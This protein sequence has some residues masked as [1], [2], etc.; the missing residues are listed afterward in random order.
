MDATP[1]DPKTW[2]DP[3]EVI[4]MFGVWDW[5]KYTEHGPFFLCRNCV[6]V[7]ARGKH[8]NYWRVCTAEEGPSRELHQ[9]SADL[10]KELSS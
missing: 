1:S 5:R 8:G 3:I 2:A 10:Q 4:P 6:P 9:L 7:E